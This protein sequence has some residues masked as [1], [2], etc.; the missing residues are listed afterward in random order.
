MRSFLR[1]FVG[2]ALICV[3][4][5][6]LGGIGFQYLFGYTPRPWGRDLFI[7]PVSGGTSGLENP[8]TFRA[9]VTDLTYVSRLKLV[10]G[11]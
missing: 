6:R 7:W 2:Y 9:A 4:I 1:R 11:R 3:L 5:E 8:T 10:V